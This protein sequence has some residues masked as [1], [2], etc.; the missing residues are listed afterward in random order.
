M[1][2]QPKTT[3]QMYEE[4]P[5]EQIRYLLATEVMGWKLMDYDTGD[6]GTKDEWLG[7]ASSNDGWSWEGRGGDSEAWD[8]NPLTDWNHWRQVEEKVMEDETLWH[9]SLKK[10]GAIT[11]DIDHHIGIYMEAHLSV[12]CRAVLAAWDSL[13]TR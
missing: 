6:Y 9:Y 4:L 11:G 8:W 7:D 3:A 13:N 1:S 10:L 2:T 12:R 5:D